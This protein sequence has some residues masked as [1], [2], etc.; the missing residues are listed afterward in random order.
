MTPS[1][2]SLGAISPHQFLTQIWQRRPLLVRQAL[3]GFDGPLDRDDLAALAGDPA[4][5]SRLVRRRAGRGPDRTDDWTVEDG[6]F[7]PSRL[8]R[9]PKRDWT[10][11]VQ[12]VDAWV[13]AV[14]ALADR[15]AFLPTWRR[16]DVMVSHAA[17]GGGVGPHVDRYDVFLLQGR[18]R[19]RWRVGPVGGDNGPERDHPRLKLLADMPVA[20]THVLDPGDMLY[21]PPGVA[22]DGEALESCVTYSIGWRAPSVGALALALAH[23]AAMSPAGDALYG[24]PE[25]PVQDDAGA[26]SPAALAHARRLVLSLLDD[27]ALMADA[28]ARE[29]TE[30]KVP[31]ALA[32]PDDPADAATVRGWLATGAVLRRPGGARLATVAAPDGV[33]LYANGERYDCP[34][35]L[36][37]LARHLAGNPTP[38]ASVLAARADDDAALALLADLINDGALTLAS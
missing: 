12:S 9:L 15:F 13:P 5:E 28:F 14:A 6:P 29:V 25:P 3:P 36:A 21:L 32:V 23:Q 10:L 19:R 2:V 35:R 16:E 20:E 33:T 27:P 8:A 11:L 4:V 38:D 1:P 22:H 17:P 7:A 34:G 31:D 37:D 26:I 30:P 24:D 18:G